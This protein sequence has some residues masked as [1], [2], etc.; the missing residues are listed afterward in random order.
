MNTM[1]QLSVKRLRAQMR[2]YAL[3][4]RQI[5]HADNDENLSEKTRRGALYMGFAIDYRNMAETWKEM[6]K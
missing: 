4:Y 3:E 5:I 2:Y 6:A 1:S